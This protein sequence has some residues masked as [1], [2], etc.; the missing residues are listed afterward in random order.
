M[1][2]PLYQFKI[3]PLIDLNLGG[4]DISFTNASL[5]MVI[6]TAL[7]CIFLLWGRSE[8]VP[9]YVQYLQEVSFG[10]VNK[11]VKNAVGEAGLPFSPYIFCIFLFIF[12]ANYIGLAPYSFTV[13]SHLSVTF[14]LAGLVFISTTLLAIIKHKSRFFR[15]F[16]P[17]GLPVM[18]SPILIPVEIISYCSRPISLSIRLFANMVAGHVM[19]KIFASFALILGE[20]SFFPSALLPVIANAGILLFECLIAFLQAYVFTMLTCIYLN[21][22]LNLH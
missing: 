14:A 5:F 21:D 15:L 7:L 3:Y 12:G 19:I 4:F 8:L 22:T 1:Y 11:L 20:S 13:T 16:F 9:S 17:K 10:F 6:V 2:D 18:I